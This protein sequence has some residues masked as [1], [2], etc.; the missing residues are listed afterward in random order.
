MKS[1]AL[2][3]KTRR[4]AP[5]CSSETEV[6]R[7]KFDRSW[8][9]TLCTES[10]FERGM[11]YF[12]EGRVTLKSA[13][14]VRVTAT[15]SGAID[16]RVE[17]GLKAEKMISA[18]CNCPYDWGGH[19]KHIVATILAINDNEGEIE[20]LM[21]SSNIKRHSL[22]ALLNS[23]K[24]E[25][26]RRFL[27]QEM[28]RTPEMGERFR[29]YF[30]KADDE[31]SL[32]EYKGQV[33]SLFD[34][35]YDHGFIPYGEELDFGA[36][37]DLAEVYFQKGDFMEAAKIYQAIFETIDER[38]EDVDDSDENYSREFTYCLE[39]FLGCI[40]QASI[41]G[42]DKTEH[43]Q[44]LFTRYQESEYFAD[45]FRDALDKL[46]TSDED[47]I[48]WRDLLKPQITEQVPGKEDF[49]KHYQSQELISMQIHV[50]SRLKEAH[51]ELYT[52]LDRFYRFD[53]KIGLMYA[54]QL[55]KDGD[56]K[57]AMEV[58]EECLTLFPDYALRD[59]RELLCE[60][61]QREDPQK[62]KETLLFLFFQS[63]DWK[64]Y[65]Q[66]KVVCSGDEWS[67][68]LSRMLDHFAREGNDNNTVIDLYLSNQMY[69]EALRGVLGQKSLYSLRRYHYKLAS[70]YPEQYFKAYQDLIF[71]F[72]GKETGRRHYREVV[73]YLQQMKE[74][75]GFEREFT[76]IMNVLREK[77]KR[78]PAFIDE[79]KNL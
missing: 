6:V 78:Q 5:H 50:L 48:C 77:H 31:R 49:H 43:I 16:Y 51:A 37:K 67:D 1:L 3:Y 44:Y 40:V 63:R 47:F 60:I 26:L 12:E 24:V 17:I 22:D 54:R 20:R 56:C 10:S 66:L 73:S 52:L 2:N 34:L 64:Y 39:S 72:A 7:F 45:N 30:S 69:D 27:D 15:V 53:D 18:T 68:I 59:V 65:Q 25:D 36:L 38:L 19:C 28:E 61:Y 21:Q 42:E 13:T 41:K 33:E 14:P 76:G 71:P 70:L 23:V 4:D 75:E 35:A 9:K 55:L 29:A 58:A 8:I 62:Y 57:R 79:M 46:C 32:A 11:G 74:I